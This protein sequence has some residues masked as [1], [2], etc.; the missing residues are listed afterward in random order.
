MQQKKIGKVIRVYPLFFPLYFLFI[1]KKMTQRFTWVGIVPVVNGMS[2]STKE[3][4]GN[5]H[6][7]QSML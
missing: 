7:S 5:T 6:L 4:N 1:R 2:H 3:F